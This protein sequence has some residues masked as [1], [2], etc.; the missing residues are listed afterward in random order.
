MIKR[1]SVLV[2]TLV[3]TLL[4]SACARGPARTDNDTHRETLAQNEK[5]PVST[6]V[7]HNGQGNPRRVL[8]AYF[9]YPDNTDA[10]PFIPRNTTS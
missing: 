5:K 10:K 8:I 6:A 7:V 4:L 2:G 1:A 3:L 9:T